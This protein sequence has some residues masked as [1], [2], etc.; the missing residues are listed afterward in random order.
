MIPHNDNPKRRCEHRDFH[1]TRTVDKS[2]YFIGCY[3]CGR[4]VHIREPDFRKLQDYIKD[5]L[6]LDHPIWAIIG[7]MKQ[8]LFDGTIDDYLGRI[9]N[10]KTTQ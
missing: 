7:K 2:Q 3:D 8:H 10:A 1:I 5:E 6:G 9:P 4:S